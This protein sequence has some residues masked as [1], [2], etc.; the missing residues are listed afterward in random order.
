M[1]PFFNFYTHACTL[2]DIKGK[3]PKT[4][5]VDLHVMNVKKE[6]SC[7]CTISVT[8]YDFYT[9]IVQISDLFALEKAYLVSYLPK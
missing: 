4:K 8:S 3:I 2:Y 7:K 1:P 9:E 5:V 6:E